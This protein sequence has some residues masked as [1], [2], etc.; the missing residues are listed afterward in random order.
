L[1]QGDALH[2]VLTDDSGRVVLDLLG[3]LIQGKPVL[4]QPIAGVVFEAQRNEK[5]A[6]TQYEIQIPKSLIGSPTFRLNV[7][8]LDNDNHY[9]KQTL[10]LGSV[11][12][13]EKGMRLNLGNP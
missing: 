9:L 13:P 12:H 4:A 11:D 3:G 2:L 5:T 8:I 1:A 6:Q 7:S 10:D